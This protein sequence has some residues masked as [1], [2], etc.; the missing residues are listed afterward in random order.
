M[1]PNQQ[2][3]QLSNQQGMQLPSLGEVLSL[4]QHLGPDGQQ[5]QAAGAEALTQAQN[6]RQYAEEQGV[7][8]LEALALHRRGQQADSSLELDQRRL[9]AYQDS[10]AGDE[11]AKTAA[12]MLGLANINPMTKEGQSQQAQLLQ[13]LYQMYQ[14]NANQPKPAKPLTTADRLKG[15]TEYH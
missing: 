3:K 12:G 9:Q 10:Q 6:N 2:G 14:S 8:S 4:I 7:P 1:N 11:R 15:R 5:R 13:Q